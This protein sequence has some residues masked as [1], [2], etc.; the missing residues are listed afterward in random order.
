MSK[1]ALRS[2]RYR[3]MESQFQTRGVVN[4]WAWA[5]PANGKGEEAALPD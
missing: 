4:Q 2:E 1:W 3:Q 5:M